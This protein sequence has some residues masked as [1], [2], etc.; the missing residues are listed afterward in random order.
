[1][2]PSDSSIIIWIPSDSQL[3]LQWFL[4]SDGKFR[5]YI[6]SRRELQLK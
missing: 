6:H 5:L 2:I 1:M 3:D 4:D